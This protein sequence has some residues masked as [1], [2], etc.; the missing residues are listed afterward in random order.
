M[1]IVIV[2]PVPSVVSALT[3]KISSV[4]LEGRSK[5]IPEGTLGE[6]LRIPARVEIPRR[7][8]TPSEF[9]TGSVVRRISSA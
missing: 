3:G 5:R 2:S 8:A 1:E 9:P 7:G 6:M 4:P